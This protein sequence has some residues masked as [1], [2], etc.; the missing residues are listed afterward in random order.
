MSTRTLIIENYD[1]LIVSKMEKSQ[2]MEV[3]DSEYYC[4]AGNPNFN[5]KKV[6][7]SQITNIHELKCS[8]VLDKY[9]EVRELIMKIPPIP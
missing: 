3:N 7:S 1:E 4:L 9:V 8:L 6:I 5:R 2:W